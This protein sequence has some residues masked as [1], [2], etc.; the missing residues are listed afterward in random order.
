[1]YLFSS[2]LIWTQAG[3]AITFM[4]FS[5][6]FRIR[7]FTPIQKKELIESGVAA[8][9]PLPRHQT[10]TKIMSHDFWSRIQYSHFFV[11]STIVAAANFNEHTHTHTP[12]SAIYSPKMPFGHLRDT[13][14]HTLFN[15]LLIL[16]YGLNVRNAAWVS[17]V[18]I[19]SQFFI[20]HLKKN[21]IICVFLLIKDCPLKNY[22]TS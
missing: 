5:C 1:M 4:T 7:D 14:T 17:R 16:I 6:K 12:Q 2:L 21:Q 19:I 8:S 10:N 9:S 15:T 20:H 13:N 11:N 22:L 3:I 18:A